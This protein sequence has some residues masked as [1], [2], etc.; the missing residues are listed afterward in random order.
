[1]ELTAL[2]AILAGEMFNVVLPEKIFP[3]ASISLPSVEGKPMAGKLGQQLSFS[4]LLGLCAH[5]M[6]YSLGWTE[7]AAKFTRNVI[8]KQFCSGESVFR[9]KTKTL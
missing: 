7:L 2:R 3:Q 8:L 4:V 5:L 9:N 1:M 6:V